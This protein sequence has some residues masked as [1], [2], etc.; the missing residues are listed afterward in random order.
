MHVVLIN[1]RDRTLQKGDVRDWR[2]LVDRKREL[3][4][5]IGAEYIGIAHKFWNGDTIWV[6]DAADLKR[7]QPAFGI[8]ESEPRPGWPFEGNGVLVGPDVSDPRMSIAELFAHIQ[9]YNLEECYVT[10]CRIRGIIPKPPPKR[11]RWRF[12]DAAPKV[13][14]VEL[15]ESFAGY[16]RTGIHAE[17]WF[18]TSKK[19][20]PISPS[21]RR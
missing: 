17:R 3:G 8:D 21:T 18:D 14:W 13:D 6:D 5:L 15:L 11:V 1:S 19:S 2:Q 9:W 20:G 7:A 16:A 12:Y 4:K 10:R